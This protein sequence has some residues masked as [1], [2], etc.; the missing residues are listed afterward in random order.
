[1][2]QPMRALASGSFSSKLGS[3]FV[4]ELASWP[5]VFLFSSVVCF[6]SNTAHRLWSDE[7]LKKEERNKLL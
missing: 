6:L 3:F 4:E 2:I 5:L 7:V 1:M